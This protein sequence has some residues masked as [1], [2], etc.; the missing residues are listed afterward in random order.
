MA[1]MSLTQTTP[2]RVNPLAMTIKSLKDLLMP[3]LMDLL[4]TTFSRTETCFTSTQVILTTSGRAYRTSSTGVVERSIAP[5]E[6]KEAQ[7]AQE[8]EFVRKIMQWKLTC[9]ARI[10]ALSDKAYILKRRADAM[11]E[12][13]KRK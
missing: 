10:E 1:L 12:R 5:H 2:W 4:K 9:Q 13:A 11:I 8:H 7:V 3:N 6:V